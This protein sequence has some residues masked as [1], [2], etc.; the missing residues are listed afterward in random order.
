MPSDA[1]LGLREADRPEEWRPKHLD[2]VAVAFVASLLV[3]NIA[4]VKLF[5]IGPL[6][7]TGGIL[8]FPLSYVFGDILTEVY[9]Y[10]RTRRIIWAGLLANLFMVA[11]L[12]VAIMLPPAPDWRTQEQ[13]RAVHMAIPRIVIASVIA[14]WAGEI[15]NSIVMSRMKVLSKGRR[16]WQR[17][18][19]STAV[20]QLV[21]SALFVVIAFAGKVNGRV[22][23]AAVLS[24]WLF[25]TLYEI[26]VLPLT[27]RIVRVLKARE[28]IEH[29]DR[30][31]S[32]N[33]LKL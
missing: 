27:Y 30:Y 3:S 31:E 23:V 15:V 12:Q 10:A 2:L 6:I 14:Y 4:A 32:Y 13:F 20:G 22:L 17:A 18:V 21:D 33:P 8:V 9:G 11:V 26:A 24:A 28:G 29:F 19:S 5:S 7:F 16:L 25:K 1:I